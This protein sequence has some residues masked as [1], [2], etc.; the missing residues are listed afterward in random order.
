MVALAAVLG[1]L[2]AVPAAQAAARGSRAAAVPGLAAGVISTVAGGVGGPGKATTVGVSPAS[3][4]FAGGSL[5]IGDALSVR[6]VDPATGQLATPAGDGASPFS[7][8]GGAGP[9]KNGSPAAKTA[10]A[11]AGVAV[12]SSGNLVIADPGNQIKGGPVIN[13]VL[14]TAASTGTFYGQ[15][16][17]SGHIYIVAGN[18][19]CGSSGDGGPAT[20]AALCGPE[21]VAVDGSG[22][23]LIADQRNSRVR[24]VAASTGT[25]YGQAMTAGDIY[26]IAGNGTNGFSGDGGPATKAKL[27]IPSGVAVD[28]AG[29]MLIADNNSRVRVVAAS[30]GTFY[31]QAMTGG[32]IYTIAGTGG[33]FGYS[34][35]GGP[36]ARAELSVPASVAVDAAGNLLVA[37]YN[38]SRVRVAAAATG[39]FYGQAMTAGTI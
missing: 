14:V 10:L 21:G 6:K 33:Y 11:P 31:G 26:T 23:L 25:F 39:T 3:V 36:A 34:G 27:G 32:D 28:T 18:G 5:Y 24:A 9:L 16:M 1:G 12:G 8:S 37:D 2:G 4:T 30:T 20:G 7:A 35:D 38:N 22:N 19:K 13:R 15:A 17:T 29:N